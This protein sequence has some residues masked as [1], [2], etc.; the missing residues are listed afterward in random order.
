MTSYSYGFSKLGFC[1][2]GNFHSNLHPI[3]NKGC[4]TGSLKSIF[5]LGSAIISRFSFVCSSADEETTVELRDL[6]LYRVTISST[7][8]PFSLMTIETHVKRGQLKI[9]MILYPKT[10]QHATAE[11]TFLAGN[12]RTGPQIFVGINGTSEEGMYL[13]LSGSENHNIYPSGLVHLQ[14]SVLINWNSMGCLK[15]LVESKAKKKARQHKGRMERRYVNN[16]KEGGMWGTRRGLSFN[17]HRSKRSLKDEDFLQPGI[18]REME[19]SDKSVDVGQTSHPK[20]SFRLSPAEMKEGKKKRKNS[21]RTLDEHEKVYCSPG[22]VNKTGIFSYFFKEPKRIMDPQWK[23]DYWQSPIPLVEAQS[24]EAKERQKMNHADDVAAGITNRFYVNEKNSEEDVW[25]DGRISAADEL[26]QKL[27]PKLLIK[28]GIIKDEK[29]ASVTISEE[30]Y[31]SEISSKV[32][33]S[34]HGSTKRYSTRKES[35]LSFE[36][37]INVPQAIHKLLEK[38]HAQYLYRN[39]NGKAF[40]ETLQIQN[41]E[42]IVEWLINYS[43]SIEAKKK[44]R[45]ILQIDT[46]CLALPISSF[47]KMREKTKNIMQI[48]GE[49]YN[50]KWLYNKPSNFNCSKFDPTFGLTHRECR[51][52]NYRCKQ[53]I[54]WPKDWDWNDP[55]QHWEDVSIHIIKLMSLAIS[56]KFHAEIESLFPENTLGEKV[57]YHEESGFDRVGY[58]K[59][60]DKSVLRMSKNDHQFEDIRPRCGL[61]ADI[62]RGIL[63]VPTEKHIGPSLGILSRKFDRLRKV[64]NGYNVSEK[65]LRDS[66]Y[67]RHL[68]TSVLYKCTEK[69]N[70]KLEEMTFGRM[71]NNSEIQEKWREYEEKHAYKDGYPVHRRR[72]DVKKAI[73]FLTSKTIENNPV[74]MICE[75]QVV[76][77]LMKKLRDRLEEGIKIQRSTTREV[78]ARNF[79]AQN[80]IRDFTIFSAAEYGELNLIETYVKDENVDVNSTTKDSIT[81]LMIASAKGHTDVVDYLIKNGADVNR[82]GLT[83][84]HMACDRGLL[85]VIKILLGNKADVNSETDSGNTPLILAVEKGFKDC[86]E[87]LINW[88]ANVNHKNRSGRSA[89]HFCCKGDQVGIAKILLKNGAN[90]DVV[91]HDG[92]TA[93]RCAAENGSIEVARILIKQKCNVNIRSRSGKSPLDIVLS[94]K[95]TNES[96]LMAKILRDAHA[97]LVSFFT[98]SLMLDIPTFRGRDSPTK[99]MLVSSVGISYTEAKI[100]KN[101][102]RTSSYKF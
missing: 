15:N 66:F 83:A 28:E 40:S 69:K 89:L 35:T 8:R 70:N 76:T 86:V 67:Y 58:E 77:S 6:D 14:W 32:T 20:P 3:P 93:I 7:L 30:E 10:T 62:I 94:Q 5:L 4:F 84:L 75:I 49:Q 1:Q 55:L 59:L 101:L 24:P 2:G 33:N 19:D 34:Q 37:S 91:D 50:V 13:I 45:E 71:A 48:I 52:D 39:E 9:A 74:Y 41:V 78:M 25:N 18:A 95:K 60:E 44:I 68:T 22:H 90:V 85:N 64:V 87:C 17:L 29:G 31:N 12:S 54:P 26:I 36:G 51:Q 11:V 65:Q 57:Q 88:N 72:E 98:E 16:L 23:V 100:S 82:K 99:T 27:A 96:L 80:K 79:G 56:E 21:K 92:H 61:N 43:C 73:E 38:G 63:V 102:E 42:P 53:P 46:F 47:E 81:P 97:E